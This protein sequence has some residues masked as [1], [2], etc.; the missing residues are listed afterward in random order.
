MTNE[1]SIANDEKYA[2]LCPESWN[3][4]ESISLLRP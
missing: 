1:G 4:D 3:A 2:E